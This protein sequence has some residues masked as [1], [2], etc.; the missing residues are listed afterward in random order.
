MQ[1][2]RAMIASH[3]Q[4]QGSTNDVLIRC[5]EECS[6][7][8]ITCTSCADAC[9]ADEM[10]AELRQ[11]IRLNVDCADVC[12]ASARLATRR[13]GGNEMAISALLDVCATVCR[14]CAEECQKHAERHEHCRI[15]ADAC[16]RCEA[17]CVEAIRSIRGD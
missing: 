13:T 17:A 14:L 12:E 4:V 9:T 7:C 3:P 1:D 15:C 11:C 2:T 10:V 6:S 8:A 5:I 16:L